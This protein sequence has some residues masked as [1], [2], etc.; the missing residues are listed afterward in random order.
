VEVPWVA[1][2]NNTLSLLKYNYDKFYITD[3]DN[4]GLVWLRIDQ[5]TG[6]LSGI[7]PVK[8]LGQSI[9]VTAYQQKVSYEQ[10]HDIDSF[11]IDIVGVN[12]FS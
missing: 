12:N 5:K 8:L 7:P 2:K 1:G 3:D 9:N 6:T 10:K 4:L 11:I